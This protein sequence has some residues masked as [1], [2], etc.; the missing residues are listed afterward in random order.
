MKNWFNK[1]Y[2]TLIITTFLIPIVIVAVVSISHVTL[3]YGITNPLSWSL[4]L[5]VGIEI[6][7]LS[8]LAALSANMGS[9]V[10][11]P[12]MI[13]TII[14]FIGNIFFAYSYINID[15]KIF[16]DWVELV[17]PFV[18]YMGVE[19]TDFIGH[20]RFLAFFAGGVLPMISLSFL[21]MLVKF[22]EEEKN[23]ET[24]LPKEINK[25][26]YGKILAEESKVVRLSDDDLKKLEGILLNPQPPEESLKNAVDDYN[27][28]VGDN[29]ILKDNQQIE[30]PNSILDNTKKMDEDNGDDLVNA[31]IAMIS[32]YED[33]KNV[34]KE[35][36]VEETTD[37]NLDLSQNDSE[38]LLT[39]NSDIVDLPTSDMDVNMDDIDWDSL[40]DFSDN[41]DEIS[42]N[43]NDNNIS[44]INDNYIVPVL[45]DEDVNEIFMDEYE[46]NFDM[47]E[48]EDFTDVM[49]SPMDETLTDVLEKSENND[50]EIPE[51]E[52]WTEEMEQ[53]YWE[54]QEPIEEDKKYNLENVEETINEVPQT[55][56]NVLPK[57]ETIEK[58]NS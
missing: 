34:T 45:S 44:S 47:V 58:K 35:E 17:S 55:E 48:E 52:G 14:Q 46:R 53:R 31:A 50:F 41:K 43:I 9:K 20:K 57:E 22:V 29:Q 32:T 19:E 13:V 16:K 40:Y 1:H 5:S 37:E 21:H 4:Y 7:A 30:I 27:K 56:D 54:A 25:K 2:K 3:W 6:A 8:A 36:E 10:Y 28:K 18:V 23:R 42:E 38:M 51:Q 33:Q 11:F 12:F 26:D 24:N 15:E 49:G 39:T